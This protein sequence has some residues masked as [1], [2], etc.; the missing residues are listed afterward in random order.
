[1]A[2][3][4][5]RKRDN[6]PDSMADMSPFM[7]ELE[8]INKIYRATITQATGIFLFIRTSFDHDIMIPAM[9][10]KRLMDFVEVA[11]GTFILAVSVEM[12]VLPYNIL[13]GGVAGLAVALEPFFHIDETLFANVS[14][15]VL[16][17]VGGWILGKEFAMKTL[18]SSLLYPVF[19]TMLL[20]SGAGV[21]IDPML[22]SFWAGVTGGVGIGIVMRTGA[23]TGGMDIPPLVLHRVTGIKISTLVVLVDTLTVCCGLLAYGLEETLLGMLSVFASGVAVDKVLGLGQSN[24]KSVQIISDEWEAIAKAI[25]KDIRRG[26]TVIDAIGGYTGDAKKMLLCVVSSREYIKLVELVR[27]IDD[28]AFVITTDATD[29]HGEGFTYS[30]AKV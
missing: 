5:S 11:L 26:C 24:A 3:S 23:S 1:M 14:V 2:S 16:L 25:Q 4:D 20:K 30:S 21:E 7:Y 9:I 13:S 22:A 28:K 10:G 15:L 17:A 8:N 18:L 6:V 27:E 29:M 12:F 19:T